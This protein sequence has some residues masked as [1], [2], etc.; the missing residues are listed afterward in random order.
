ML[1]AEE[2]FDDDL[3]DGGHDYADLAA[4]MGTPEDEEVGSDKE[5]DGHSG[6]ELGSGDHDLSILSDDDEEDLDDDADSPGSDKEPMADSGSDQEADDG[7]NPF[8]LAEATD[9]EDDLVQQGTL[10]VQMPPVLAC[11]LVPMSV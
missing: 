4:A 8:E 10:W 1:E 3:A 7:V 11:F 2:D 6:S 5:G 9:S